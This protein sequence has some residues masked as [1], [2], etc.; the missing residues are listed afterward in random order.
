MTAVTTP[1]P[2]C[3]RAISAARLTS[4][5]GRAVEAVA[6]LHDGFAVLGFSNGGGMA[7]HVATRRAVT[8]AVLASGTLPLAMLGVDSWP[9]TTAVQVH[10]A[11]DDPHRN[12]EWVQ[13]LVTSVRDSGAPLEVYAQYPIAGHL[14]TDPTLPDYDANA[15]E[16]F[17]QRVLT[18]LAD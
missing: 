7:E 16:L 6:D 10:Y 15:T 4:L 9:A 17:W 8:K 12:E 1:S 3:C 14:F 11:A 2:R 5:M 13:S 18:F